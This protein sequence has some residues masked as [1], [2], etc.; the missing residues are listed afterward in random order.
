MK[1]NLPPLNALRSFEAAARLS[2]FSAAAAELNVTP[3]AIS[4]Q[5][6]KLEDYLGVMLFHRGT[7]EVTLTATGSEYLTTA[8]ALFTT[9]HRETARIRKS[10]DR[11]SL[12]IWSSMTVAMRWLVPLLTD[13]YAQT[14][15][16]EVELT[17]SLRPLAENAREFDFAIRYGQG[18]WPGFRSDL[19]LESDLIPVCA[20]SLLDRFPN[21]NVHDLRGQTLLHSQVRIGD[22]QSYLTAT[23]MLDL[24]A[25]TGIKFESSAIA[26][27]AAANGLG[28]ALGQRR[29]VQ[30]D[31]DA[32]RLVIP[33]D[34][35]IPA[36]GAFYLIYLPETLRDRRAADFRR[37]LLQVAAADVNRAGI[38]GGRL[39]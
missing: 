34:V 9:L 2:S 30:E 32:G 37:W 27:Q 26:Y 3:G 8:S 12:T 39:V 10:G 13:Y 4:R 31:L 11:S 35:A 15:S 38:A 7:R 1:M 33:I 29:L 28:I 36:G 6:A 21:R 24:S 20:P 17:T 25:S 14:R 16:I 22:W 18:D 19:V 23:G 5:I